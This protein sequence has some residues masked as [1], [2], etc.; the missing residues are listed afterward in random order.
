M[1]C[2]CVGK[3]SS[4]VSP[5]PQSGTLLYS[6]LNIPVS[7][8]TMST[9][10]ERGAVLF[11]RIFRPVFEKSAF[12]GNTEHAELKNRFFTFPGNRDKI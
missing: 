8:D 6:L 7:F 10:S 12:C 3:P 1:D 9:A 5:V 2:F 11:A 4:G